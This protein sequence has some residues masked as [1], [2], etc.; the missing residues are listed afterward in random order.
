MKIVPMIDSLSCFSAGV[1]IT[2]ECKAWAKNINHEAIEGRGATRFRLFMS[3]G[4]SAAI[5]ASSLA[6]I[7][8]LLLMISGMKF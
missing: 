4:S 2:V 8:G 5:R 1:I 7:L 6:F 3:S